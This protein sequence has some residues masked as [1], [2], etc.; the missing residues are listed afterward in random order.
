MLGERGYLAFPTKILARKPPQGFLAW[1][2]SSC[3]RP[4]Q[5]RDESKDPPQDSSAAE[6]GL[7]VLKKNKRS[8]EKADTSRTS[9]SEKVE[10][11]TV[12]KYTSQISAERGW[13]G[14][15]KL[16][17]SQSLSATEKSLEISG[18]PE[19][20]SLSGASNLEP[21]KMRQRSSSAD[22]REQYDRERGTSGTKGLGVRQP[23]QRSVS[24]DER[25]R[26]NDN[27]NVKDALLQNSKT[28]VSA[29]AIR[30]MEPPLIKMSP[31]PRDNDSV[32]EEDDASILEDLPSVEGAGRRKA[33]SRSSSGEWSLSPS[34]NLLSPVHRSDSLASVYSSARYGTVEVQGEIE[35]GLEYNY[36]AE[37]LEIHVK[38][39]RDL[40]PIDTKR[41]RSDP[42]VKVYLLPDKSKSGKRK[43]K[44]KKNTLNPVFDELLKFQITL[45]GLQTRTLWLSVWHSDMFGRNDF[46]GEVTLA[47]ENKGFDDPSPH[48]FPLQER[49]EQLDE[50]LSYKGDLLIAL[51][52][53]P[54]NVTSPVQKKGKRQSQGS[55][56]VL[57][58]EAKNLTAMKADGTSDPFCKCYLLPDKGR[59]SKQKTPVLKRTCN[60]VWNYT[61]VYE[62][63]SLQ[64]L[65]ER[66]L[67]LT[68]WDH[69]RLGS[70]DFLGGLR[71]NLGTGKHYGKAVDWMDA[72]GQEVTLWQ[73]M[74]ERPNFW[75]QDCLTLRPSLE[76]RRSSQELMKK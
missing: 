57:V 34:D 45:H 25:G 10:E 17:S 24:A 21:S 70:N 69:D 30:G 33:P 72:S 44:V 19:G 60:P 43:T 47:L 32:F 42:Y 11:V 1:C 63:V 49:A 15:R 13:V 73:H 18:K 9:E 55:L 8:P 39:C 66:G 22:Y 76:H 6:R 74:L 54:P 36:K 4:K 65:S 59:S 58:T 46:L 23:K 35:F 41:N 26:K 20:R 14:A 3:C 50:L 7:D 12:K 62:D 68:V 29:S 37:A 27:V 67:E 53:D 56:Y 71:F 64:E 38:Q 2:C 40:A 31:A 52:F 48:W 5:G 75:V 16:D 51:K 28:A 61:F